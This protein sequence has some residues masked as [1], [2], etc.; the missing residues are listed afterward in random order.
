MKLLIAC[1]SLTGAVPIILVQALLH[2]KTKPDWEITFAFTERILIDRARNALA[3]K[4][5]NGGFDYLFFLDD[6]T[7]PEVDIL[8]R[9]VE[10]G[11]DIVVAPVAD[12]NCEDTI[13]LFEDDLKPLKE[14]KETR[15]VGAGGM[16]ST[17]ISR[18][19]LIAVAK[20]FGKPF[21]F[22]KREDGSL[23]G[24][25]VN[26][27]IRA[28]ACGKETWAIPMKVTHIGRR[29]AFTYNPETGEH[30]TKLI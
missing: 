23:I 5:L 12:R 25:D 10:L 2:F 26:F 30:E 8:T 6:D 15:R 13:A 14:L 4:A 16:S 21:E 20:T 9:M 17:L 1:P 18:E 24:E 22:E 27:C 29:I 19:T 28:G 7:V 11:K 3:E